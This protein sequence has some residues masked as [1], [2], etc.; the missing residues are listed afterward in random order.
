MNCSN[1]RSNL[2]AYRFYTL[3]VLLSNCTF[4]FII[5]RNLSHSADQLLWV[6]IRRALISSSLEQLSYPNISLPLPPTLRGGNFV[7]K[8]V[9]LT[10]FF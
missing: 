9:K 1:Q 3:S 6:G 4:G 7:V 5:L 10:Y 8:R 2:Y